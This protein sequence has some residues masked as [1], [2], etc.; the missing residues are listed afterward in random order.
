MNKWLVEFILDEEPEFLIGKRFSFRWEER[1]ASRL[2]TDYVMLDSSKGAVKLSYGTR[3]FEI[4]LKDGGLFTR[5]CTTEPLEQLNPRSILIQSV[6]GNID[7][8]W[9]WHR[10]G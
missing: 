8:A 3:Y 6:L 10:N 4:D 1:E 5:R 7:F 2:N 9:R